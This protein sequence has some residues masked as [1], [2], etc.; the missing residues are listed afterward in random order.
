MIN[1]ATGSALRLVFLL[2][3]NRVAGVGRL[4]LG[5]QFSSFVLWGVGLGNVGLHIAE[6]LSFP[7]QCTKAT[8]G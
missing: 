7:T 3:S 1:A 5:D 6:A 2:F 8:D 4:S